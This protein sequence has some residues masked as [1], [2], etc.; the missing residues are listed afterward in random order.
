MFAVTTP[1]PMTR[2]LVLPL[3]LGLSTGLPGCQS[4]LSVLVINHLQEQIS[5]SVGSDSA[6]LGPGESAGL[7][8]P[9]PSG[10]GRGTLVVALRGCRISYQ[11]PATLDDYPWLSQVNGSVPLQLEADF[12]LYAV[13]P[14]SDGGIPLAEAARL[15]AG[16]FPLFPRS[17]QCG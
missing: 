13:P 1:R 4:R 11:A 6:V 14:R 2:I 7:P 10:A 12:K 16:A 9:D 15:Q 5:V 17:R 3:L 8:Y